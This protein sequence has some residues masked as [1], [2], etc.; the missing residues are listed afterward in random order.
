MKTLK[1]N[2]NIESNNESV[3]EY[4]L[5]ELNRSFK[6]VQVSVAMNNYKSTLKDINGNVIGSWSL[7]IKEN[8][9]NEND[10]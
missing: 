3:Q 6:N 4:D 8:E 9:D 7:D 5:L 10:T 1:F 2:M